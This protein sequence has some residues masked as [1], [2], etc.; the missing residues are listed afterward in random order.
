MSIFFKDENIFW[1]DIKILNIGNTFHLVI[2][3]NSDWPSVP[4][5]GAQ[6]PSFCSVSAA[7]RWAQHHTPTSSLW[8]TASQEWPVWTPQTYLKPWSQPF[9]RIFSPMSWCLTL[10]FTISTILNSFTKLVATSAHS[11]VSL[12]GLTVV[13]T[14]PQDSEHQEAPCQSSDLPSLYGIWHTRKLWIMVA[15][16]VNCIYFPCSENFLYFAFIFSWNFFL[17]VT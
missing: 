11:D 7:V 3:T 4:S 10:T 2:K 13:P 5:P 17:W 8:N 6:R 14:R 1:F 15:A 9:P 12:L 16:E